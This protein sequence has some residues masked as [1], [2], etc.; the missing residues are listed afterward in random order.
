MSDVPTGRRCRARRM[1]ATYCNMAVMYSS[2]RASLKMVMPLVAEQLKKWAPVQ[3]GPIAMY[4][5]EVCTGAKET[6]AGSPPRQPPWNTPP[7]PRNRTVHRVYGRIPR[8][9]IWNTPFAGFVTC[10]QD[11][12]L[13]TGRAGGASCCRGDVP[14]RRGDPGGD[15]LR[16]HRPCLGEALWADWGRYG[17]QEEDPLADGAGPAQYTGG[18]AWTACHEGRPRED[19]KTV[20]VWRRYEGTPPLCPRGPGVDVAVAHGA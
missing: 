14:S 12:V 3:L 13:R 20:F 15:P 18:V 9:L 1:A 16:C 10:R 19:C 8:W 7:P 5:R 6:G 11:P 17:S 2:S 4:K